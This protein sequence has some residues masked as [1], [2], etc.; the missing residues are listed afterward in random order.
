MDENQRRISLKAGLL[1]GSVPASGSLSTSSLGLMTTGTTVTPFFDTTNGTVG[2]S[3]VGHIGIYQYPVSTQVVLQDYSLP[4][5]NVKSLNKKLV[6]LKEDTLYV[7]TD[8]DGN[9]DPHTYYIKSILGVNPQTQQVET[10]EAYHKIAF[11]R[12]T[13]MIDLTT[14]E[15]SNTSEPGVSNEQLIIMITHRLKLLNEKFACDENEQAI[16]HLEYALAWLDKR[17]IDR[18][19]RGVAGQHQI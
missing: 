7:T 18:F 6:G 11:I 2:H 14:G 13:E 8:D 12:K 16:K 3:S 4:L 19:K 10:T 9:E 5:S 15:K 1:T 17:T